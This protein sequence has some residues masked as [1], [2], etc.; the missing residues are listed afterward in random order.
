MITQQPSAQ[1][2]HTNNF[3]TNGSAAANADLTNLSQ[4]PYQRDRSAD[5]AEFDFNERN[6]TKDMSPHNGNSR[7]DVLDNFMSLPKQ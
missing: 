1:Q 3:N 7:G 5:R 6:M 2:L 4:N